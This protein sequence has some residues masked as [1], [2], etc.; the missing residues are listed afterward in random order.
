MF[1]KW[2]RPDSPGCALGVIEKG[3]LVY[4]RGYGS[5]NLDYDVPISSETVFYLASVSKQFTAACAVLLAQEG[6]IAL[7]DD[8]RKYFPELPEYEETVTIRHLLHH[9]SGLKDYLTL[10]SVMGRNF[11]DVHTHEEALQVIAGQAGLNFPPGEKYMYSNTG[12]LLLS[13][14]VKR[15]TGKSMREYADE[16]MFQPL[17]MQHSHFHDDR[18]M[19]VK[20]RAV[21]YS[22]QQGEGEEDRFAINDLRNFALIGS[23]GLC[24]NIED[25]SL[26][27]QNFDHAKV[28]GPEFVETMLTRGKLNDGTQ[29]DYACGLSVGWYRGLKTIRHGGGMMGFRTHFLRFPEQRLTV[30]CLGNLAEIRPGQLAQEVAELYLPDEFTKATEQYAGAYRNEELATTYTIEMKDGDL[31]A[32]RG[33]GARFP[34]KAAEGSDKFSVRRMPVKFERDEDEQIAGFKV[35]SGRAGEIRFVRVED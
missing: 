5:A 13:E 34:L 14:L 12:Y 27:D 16:K 21:G 20:Q 11:E 23:G 4:Q 30:I 35:E 19:I 18:G 9:T 22:R 2:D 8:I 7:D 29:I 25:L 24:S 17:G 10:M 15:V 33:I 6:G 1:S 28:G 26:W 31:V 32:G 3:K